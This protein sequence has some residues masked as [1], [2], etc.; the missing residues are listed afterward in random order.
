MGVHYL[1]VRAAAI[2]DPIGNN[3]WDPSNNRHVAVR[4]INVYTLVEH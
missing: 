4:K 1:I 2:G 3:P